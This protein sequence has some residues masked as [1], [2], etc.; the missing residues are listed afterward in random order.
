[1]TFR[2][3]PKS[4]PTRLDLRATCFEGESGLIAII[5]PELIVN[6]NKSELEIIVKYPWHQGKTSLIKRITAEEPKLLRHG[7]NL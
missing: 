2:A 7:A 1:M 3:E 6:Y 4:A 5:P